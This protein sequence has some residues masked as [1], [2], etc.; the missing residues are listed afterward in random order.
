MW[1]VPRMMGGIE[2]FR[3]MTLKVYTK[4]N[5]KIEDQEIEVNNIC[6]KPRISEIDFEKIKNQ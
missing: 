5:E 3:K 2:I 1:F 6:F 4:Y